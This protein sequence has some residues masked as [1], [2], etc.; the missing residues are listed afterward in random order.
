MPPITFRRGKWGE[1][2]Y[3]PVVLQHI[4][5]GTPEVCEGLKD[6]KCKIPANNIGVPNSF[7][8][9]LAN[10]EDYNDSRYGIKNLARGVRAGWKCQ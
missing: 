6:K 4:L 5:F 8:E 1:P 2:K 3:N 9:A 10:K 7:H